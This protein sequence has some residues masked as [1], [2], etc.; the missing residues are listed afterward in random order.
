MGLFDG[1][2]NDVVGSS[3]DGD[4]W[5]GE[6]IRLL[7]PASRDGFSGHSRCVSCAQFQNRRRNQ[8][9]DAMRLVV[10]LEC[11]HSV[12]AV[13]SRMVSVRFKLTRSAE[14]R[15]LEKTSEAELKKRRPERRSGIRSRCASWRKSRECF[16]R[17]ATPVPD[18]GRKSLRTPLSPSSSLR[19]S[20]L[21]ELPSSPVLLLSS[22]VPSSLPP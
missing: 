21:R 5:R 1:D 8:S 13:R 20:S 10:R 16:R 17:G 15:S 9:S 2:V 6:A 19:A 11:G 3:E 14:K 7:S 4:I 18:R 22:P 12:A